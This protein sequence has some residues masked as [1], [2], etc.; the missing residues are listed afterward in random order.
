M[1]LISVVLFVS[2]N[3]TFE[4]VANIGLQVNM[5]FYLMSDYHYEPT[6]AAIIMN[7]WNAV[8]YFMTIFGAFLSDSYLGR[9]SVIAWS[10]IFEL[11]VCI[12]IYLYLF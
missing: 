1:T 10:T 3:E 8:S 11:L 5:V 4:K 9:F 12:F 6:S 7:L 2:A